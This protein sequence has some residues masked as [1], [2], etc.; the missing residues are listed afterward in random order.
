VAFILQHHCPHATGKPHIG[1]P[2]IG[3]NSQIISASSL[4][5]SL[6]QTQKRFFRH[7]FTPA[8]HGEERRWDWT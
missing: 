7:R 2:D 1:R 4:Q 5:L 8:L 6:A 3:G